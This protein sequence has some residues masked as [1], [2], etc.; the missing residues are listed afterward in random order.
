MATGYL[1]REK[2]SRFQMDSPTVAKCSKCGREHQMHELQC[3]PEVG[4]FA[5]QLSEYMFGSAAEPK[6]PLE[7]KLVE[8]YGYS[9]K[10]VF[11][12]EC[13]SD[14]VRNASRQAH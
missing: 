10:C 7:G 2:V 9:G 13:F 11:C 1:I 4:E 14:V 5:K 6:A 3:L 8:K 12:E